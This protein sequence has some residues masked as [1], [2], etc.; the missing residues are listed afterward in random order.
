MLQAKGCACN[1][2]A[3]AGCTFEF[4]WLEGLHQCS[5]CFS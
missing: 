5:N 4:L 3:G 2:H 1:M